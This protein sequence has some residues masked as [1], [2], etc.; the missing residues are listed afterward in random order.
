MN[1]SELKKLRADKATA[2][3]SLTEEDI[4]HQ[5]RIKR[6]IKQGKLP[7]YHFAKNPKGQIVK[8]LTLVDTF[9]ILTKK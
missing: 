2:Q 9:A 6:L 4:K 3:A 5:K 1:N 8:E 7:R